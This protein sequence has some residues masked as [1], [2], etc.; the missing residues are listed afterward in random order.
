MAQLYTIN[1]SDSLEQ[2]AYQSLG[3]LGNWR[4]IADK[5]GLEIFN[6]LPV[7]TKI[8]LPTLAEIEEKFNPGSFNDAILDLSGL[9]QSNVTGQNP[10]QL[11][12]WIL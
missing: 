5:A 6:R 11:I 7:G 12:E 1:N 4:D 2:I 9:R 3:D 10:Y 8:E